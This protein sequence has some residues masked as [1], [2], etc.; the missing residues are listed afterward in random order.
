MLKPQGIW[1]V[2]LVASFAS[3]GCNRVAKDIAYDPA[4]TDSLTTLDIYPPQLGRHH[5]VVIFIHGGSYV[6][7][8]K[9]TE[10][11]GKPKA[12]AGEGYVFV[13]INYRLSPAV[14]HPAHIQD[15]AKAI[16]WVYHN[17]GRYGGDSTRLFVLGHSSG[18][19]MAALIA[20]NERYLN[21][22]GL[23]LSSLSGAILLDGTA[24]DVPRRFANDS[25]EAHRLLAV[26]GDDPAAWQEGSAIY[27]CE[28]DKGIPPFLIFFL[29][30]RAAGTQQSQ[31]LAAALAAAEVR[32][33]IKP[34]QTVGH[35]KLNLELGLETDP[36]TADLFAFLKRGRDTGTI[37]L[38]KDTSTGGRP[39]VASPATQ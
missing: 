33:E 6:G 5:P 27:H 21:A 22:E 39:A 23:D 34:I 25:V 12:F 37:R 15:V 19:S 30:A 1:F 7:G 32:V 17:I 16:A 13:A 9:S 8:D 24:Y 18:A 3:Q 26:F 28:K 36:A 11:G 4:G 35:Y 14:K 38:A 10:V 31:A 20:T 29:T 2:A